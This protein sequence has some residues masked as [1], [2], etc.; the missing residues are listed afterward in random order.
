MKAGRRT[1]LITLM[2]AVTTLLAVLHPGIGSTF[3]DDSPKE[4]GH[5]VVEVVTCET[6]V[7]ETE[8]ARS[9]TMTPVSI[10]I[11]TPVSDV[12]AASLGVENPMQPGE[13]QTTY[14]DSQWALD[15]IGIEEENNCITIHGKDEDDLIKAAD[16]LSLTILGIMK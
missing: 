7:I 5:P 10:D 14:D 3:A 13:K 12:Q 1:R 4:C 16:R 11:E 6:S 15:K 8:P 2:V 9:N